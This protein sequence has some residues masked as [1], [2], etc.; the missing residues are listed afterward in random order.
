MGAATKRGPDKTWGKYPIQNQ[1][2][3]RHLPIARLG[4]FIAIDLM[5][6]RLFIIFYFTNKTKSGGILVAK[7]WGG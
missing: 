4:I 2:F 1:H 3:L 7:S 5:I 6:L